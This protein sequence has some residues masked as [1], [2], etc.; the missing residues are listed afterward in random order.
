MTMMERIDMVFM[1]A[2]NTLKRMNLMDDI[3]K[4]FSEYGYLKT[5][6]IKEMIK[7]YEE[8]IYE[9]VGIVNTLR[10]DLLKDTEADLFENQLRILCDELTQLN[11]M[12]KIMGLE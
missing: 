4:T 1:Q 3:K 12:K 5:C 11:K 7:E 9:D 10:G 8:S 6:E 2:D